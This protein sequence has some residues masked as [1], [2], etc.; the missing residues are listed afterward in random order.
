MTIQ[1]HAP[2]AASRG[3]RACRACQLEAGG[4]SD[5][6]LHTQLYCVHVSALRPAVSLPF[7]VAFLLPSLSILSFR[8]M[9]YFFFLS[10]GWGVIFFKIFYTRV[11]SE[12]F[13]WNCP[14]FIFHL[15]L[16]IVLPFVYIRKFSDIFFPILEK[17]KSRTLYVPLM[18]YCPSLVSPS[19]ISQPF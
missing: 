2:P 18:F 4:F 16:S 3:S 8:C 6:S 1:P 11:C 17:K 9:L 5:Y 10:W 7:F 14:G 19:L 12:S 15:P 13:R